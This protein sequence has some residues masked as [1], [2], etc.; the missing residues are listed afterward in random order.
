ML[1]KLLL[2]ITLLALVAA[3]AMT[4]AEEA[5][6]EGSVIAPSSA[7][8]EPSTGLD[9]VPFLVTGD[10]DV[11]YR[12]VDTSGNEDKYREDLNYRTGPRLFNFNLD[13]TPVGSSFFDLANVYAS[14]LGGEPFQYLGVTVQKFGNY[15][16][17][18]RR[19]QAQYFYHDT[20]LPVDVAGNPAQA[21]AGDFHTFNFERTTDIFDFDIDINEMWNV[22]VKANRTDR[23][24]ASTITWDVSRDEFEFDKPLDWRKNDFALGF[25]A[26]GEKFSIYFDQS[27][28]DYEDDGFT[29]LP[30]LSQGEDPEDA[31][32]LFTFEQLLPYSYETPQTTVKANLRPNPR[33]TVNVGYVYASLDGNFDYD[34]QATGIAFTGAPLAD[35]FGGDGTIDRTLNLF[36]I[37]GVFDIGEI[38]SVFGALEIRRLEQNGSLTC[39]IGPCEE[40]EL[41]EGETTT[42]ANNIDSN[43]FK[44]GVRVFPSARGQITGGLQWE[45]RKVEHIH[46]GEGEE[47]PNTKRQPTFFFNGVYAHPK[48]NLLAEY[49]RGSYENPFTLVSPETLNRFKVKAKIFPTEAFTITGI[50]YIRRIDYEEVPVVSVVPGKLATDNYSI[51]VRYAFEDTK[52]YG[53]YTRQEWDQTIVNRGQ[54]APGFGGGV[55]FTIDAS[56]DSKINNLKAGFNH[57]FNES[58][59]AGADLN[60]FDNSG[61]FPSDF[62][63][64]FPLSAFGSFPLDWTQFQLWGQF[65]T[66]A[67]YLI[68]IAYQ[69]NDYNEERWDFDDYDA[70]MVTVS[71]GYAF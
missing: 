42:T 19:N 17:T 21:R 28:R 15:K 53:G 18:Y 64:S 11:G 38:S 24:G 50:I 1:R 34:E 67:G 10:F 45:D 44:V 30:G 27:W 60:W 8:E 55:P 23:V 40:S 47:Q 52:V 61:T 5:K 43:M 65:K 4:W 37:E 49:E 46:D 35:H 39:R 68:R 14:H 66:T 31:T 63:G 32:V 13:I 22:F 25:E 9:A 57:N 26:K 62:P 56:Y 33:T 58:F 7:Q 59:L 54:T 29:F 12:W 3:P 71:V 20:V 69:R 41:E 16:F 6:E 36:D 2:A 70:N 48:A 51:Y